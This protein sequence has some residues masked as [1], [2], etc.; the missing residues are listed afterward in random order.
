MILRTVVL[1]DDDDQPTA[2]ADGNSDERR[3]SD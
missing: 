2:E 1:A 3:I